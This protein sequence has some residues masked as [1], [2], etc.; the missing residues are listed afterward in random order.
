M[1]LEPL[2]DADVRNAAGAAAPERDTDDGAR[3]L[4]GRDRR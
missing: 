2:D 1:L 3:G 4:C